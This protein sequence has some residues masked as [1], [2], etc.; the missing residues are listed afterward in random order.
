MTSQLRTALT[1]PAVRPHIV[2][3]LTAL[4]DSTVRGLKGLK[5]LPVKSGYSAALKRD[6]KVA[7]RGVNASVGDLA[8]ALAPLWAQYQDGG[9]T[10]G[11]GAFLAARPTEG[12][13]AVM[14]LVEAQAAAAGGKA[15]S[16]LSAFGGM[17]RE[18]LGSTLPGV[19]E[20]IERHAS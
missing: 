5:F 2:A 4:L 20:I 9:E 3:E 13:E 15:Q 18:V 6:S 16:A 14:T 12:T 19:G 8:D 11:F 10:G 17:A 1:D 7:E